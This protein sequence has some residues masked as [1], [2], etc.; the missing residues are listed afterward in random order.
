MKTS[1][2]PSL[3][4][5]K[6]PPR[7]PGLGFAHPGAPGLSPRTRPPPPAAPPPVPSHKSTPQVG[8]GEERGGN[9]EILGEAGHGGSPMLFAL[10][11]FNVAA[12]FLL[13]GG[14]VGLRRTILRPRQPSVPHAPAP[15][16]TYLRRNDLR[17]GKPMVDASL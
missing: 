15:F 4:A 5:K 14:G 3:P 1:A 8:R 7:G 2:G 11:C 13:H 16:L 9:E 10:S 17:D 12:G 6:R